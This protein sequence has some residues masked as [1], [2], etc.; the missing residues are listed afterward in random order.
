MRPHVEY[1]IQ[2]WRPQYRKD[3]ELLQRVQRRTTKMIR[4]LDY[5][6][7]EDRLRELSLFSL[8]KAAR[9]PHCSLPEFKR[10]L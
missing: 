10:V 1:C 6:P 4:G 7:Y 3:V 9:R 5:L 2:V 8:E